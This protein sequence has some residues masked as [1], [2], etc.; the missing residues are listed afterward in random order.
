[1][2]LVICNTEEAKVFSKESS[3][4]ILALLSLDIKILFFYCG[5]F[6]IDLHISMKVLLQLM[7]LTSNNDSLQ[8]AEVRQLFIFYQDS[9]SLS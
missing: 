8:P 3:S 1:M 9:M 7:P 4:T 2:M 5:I 6:F